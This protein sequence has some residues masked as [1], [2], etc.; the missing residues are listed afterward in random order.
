MLGLLIF[1]RP[2]AEWD[3]RLNLVVAYIQSFIVVSARLVEHFSPITSSAAIPAARVY[4][5]R[6]SMFA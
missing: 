4:S 1:N 3:Y 2:A 6:H 5:F